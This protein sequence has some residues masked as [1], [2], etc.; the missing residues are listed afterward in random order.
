M[1]KRLFIADKEK[2]GSLAME[3]F[4]TSAGL[5]REGKKFQR[6]RQ[7]ALRM[8]EVIEERVQP[9]GQ[10]AYYSAGEIR[11]DKDALT[12]DG[13]TFRCRAFEQIKSSSVKGLYVYAC[14]AGDYSLPEE[15]T[16]NQ[17]YAD[18]WGTALADAVRH[19]LKGELEKNGPL[20]DS[21]GPGFYGMEVMETHSIK[22]LLDFDQLGVTVKESGILVPV[23]S[24]A[25]LFF[26]VNDQYEPLDEA[27]A[28]CQGN[29]RSCVS[30]QFHRGIAGK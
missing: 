15:S 3:Y 23:K 10:Y 30:C 13:E 6:M 8:R 12:V 25:G 14:S 26:H 2:C 16:L 29:A 4:L 28:S 21:F 19:L 20:S 22:K 1:E 27:C 5:N 11:K 7:D 9:R 24:C 18:L 17:V